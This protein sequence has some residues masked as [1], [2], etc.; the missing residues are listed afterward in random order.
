MDE[1]R[2][3]FEMARVLSQSLDKLADCG[4]FGVDTQL[5]LERM[6]WEVYRKSNDFKEICEYGWHF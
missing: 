3:A 4:L 6:S 5:M 2:K 1:V